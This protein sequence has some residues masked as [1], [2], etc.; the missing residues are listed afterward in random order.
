VVLDTRTTLKN[1]LFV[2]LPGTTGFP[3]V[4]KLIVKKA[5]SMGYH[6]IGLMYPNSTDLYTA[7]AAS[8]DNT[9]FGKCRQE[10]FDGS[11]QT[12]GVSV[13]ADNCIRTR[14]QKLLLYLNTMHP[15]Q[16]WDQYLSN[17]TVDW[18]K[19][20]LAG[21]SQGGGHALYI[22][23]Q[24]AL[25]R[26]ISFSS[27]DWNTNLGR[28]ANWVSV[29]GQTPIGK[30]YTINSL[31]DQIFAYSNVQTQMADM[32][33]IGPAMSIE[34]NLKPYQNSHT[35]TTRTSAAVFVLFPDHNMTCLDQYIP[36]TSTGAVLPIIDQA[37]TYLIG[38]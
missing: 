8:S 23:K 16:R 13:N 27:I 21:H 12:T 26:A 22:S 4:Y 10:I 7:S 15:D 31:Y 14:L 18:S 38:E 6:S 24:V 20:I 11:D 28:S 29:P 19:I 34:D 30:L 32:G 36:K 2:F 37:W 1:K 33:M 35:L 17:G 9:L 5:A 25:D 3:S